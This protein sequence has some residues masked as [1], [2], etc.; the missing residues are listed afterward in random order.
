MREI[1]IMRNYVFDNLL[2]LLLDT[3]RGM[4]GDHLQFL[5]DFIQTLIEAYGWGHLK[6]EGFGYPDFA[7]RY[8]HQKVIF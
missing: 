6:T 1:V 8:L 3:E 4:G 2:S 5:F 7:P